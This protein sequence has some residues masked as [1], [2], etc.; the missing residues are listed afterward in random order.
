[1]IVLTDGLLCKMRN[2]E[3]SIYIRT[4]YK[5]CQEAVEIASTYIVYQSTILFVQVAQYGLTVNV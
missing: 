2:I 4:A 1:M 5:R 3:H